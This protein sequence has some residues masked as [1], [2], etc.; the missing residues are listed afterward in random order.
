[1]ERS[2][3]LAAF[4]LTFFQVGFGSNTSKEVDISSFDTSTIF[5]LIGQMEKVPSV[6]YDN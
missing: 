1:M 4:L 2:L 6:D 3:R 5:L